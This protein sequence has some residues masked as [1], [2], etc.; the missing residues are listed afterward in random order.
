MNQSTLINIG[1]LFVFIGILIITIGSAF[2]RGANTKESDFKFS[3]FGLI[4]PIPVGFSN[5]KK[6]FFFSV[7]LTVIIM[8]L[9]LF[10]HFFKHT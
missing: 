1:I 4:G 5:D 6:L 8:L 10:Y 3:F 9:F 2:V 7:F